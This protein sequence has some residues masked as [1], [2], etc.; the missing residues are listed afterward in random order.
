MLM[1]RYIL[2]SVAILS[3]ALA[4]KAQEASFTR[5]QVD[6][7]IEIARSS[8][9]APS[10]DCVLLEGTVEEV[11]AKLK[12]RGWRNPF[13]R[14]SEEQ[15]SK[16]G[17]PKRTRHLK[18]VWLEGVFMHRKANLILYPVSVENRDIAYASVSITMHGNNLQKFVEKD[19]MPIVH[20]Y[21]GKYGEYRITDID[22]RYEESGR[23]TTRQD[24]GC[25]RHIITFAFEDPEI[26][27][28]AQTDCNG[29]FS[30]VVQYINTINLATKLLD[31]PENY[32]CLPPPPRPRHHR[33]RN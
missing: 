23:K 3:A 18:G 6:S 9:E 30:I 27:L 16:A 26:L 25:N 32:H 28:R 1:K 7:I 8:Y 5:A 10:I 33:Q 11:A 4:G 14:F 31:S 12:E 13:S 24:Y 29:M 19:V 2:T 21:A 15:L 22:R 20:R 17:F